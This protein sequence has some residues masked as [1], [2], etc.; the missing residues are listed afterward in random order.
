MCFKGKSMLLCG[1]ISHS[2]LANLYMHMFKVHSIPLNVKINLN[3]QYILQDKDAR[4][5]GNCFIRLLL[6]GYLIE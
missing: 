1:K 5:H 2:I 3:S 4:I 6:T